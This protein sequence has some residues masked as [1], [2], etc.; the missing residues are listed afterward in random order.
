MRLLLQRVRHASVQCEGR[1]VSC[2]GPGLLVLAGFGAADGPELPATKSWQ[3]ILKKLVS[4]RIFPDMAGRMNEDVL[5]HGGQLLVVSQ[6]TLY[7]DLRSGRRPSFSNAAPPQTAR[8]LYDTLLTDLDALAPGRVAGGVFGGDMDVTL[9]NWGPVT[10]QL[11]S[12][13]FAGP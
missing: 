11:D 12:A 10:M 8:A 3:T 6:F 4:L 7:A 13:D 2:I 5:Q 9:L 1:E